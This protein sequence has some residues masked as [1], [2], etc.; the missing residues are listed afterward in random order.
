MNRPLSDSQHRLNHIQMP[1]C[2]LTWGCLVYRWLV[3]AI[4]TWAAPRKNCSAELSQGMM[5]KAVLTWEFGEFVMWQSE[6]ITLSGRDPVREWVAG[7]GTG[8][9]S[10]RSLCHCS[11]SRW[12]CGVRLD[13]K[14]Q[15]TTLSRHGS[16]DSYYMSLARSTPSWGLSASS[17]RARLHCCADV[18]LFMNL[19]L[20]LYKPRT[21]C[22]QKTERTGVLP[23]IFL[24]GQENI[25]RVEKKAQAQW[26][27]AR[28]GLLAACSPS[29][30]A[31]PLSKVRNET[32]VWLLC[33][34]LILLAHEALILHM[35]LILS[36]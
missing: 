25:F 27:E 2:T 36:D 24:R 13:L 5:E 28:P 35:L 6:S 20:L 26:S 31:L 32:H 15:E 19:G 16:G 9:F 22:T 4:M 33:Y 8:A 34:L 30:G 14:E 17:P 21:S 3:L 18:S 11:I 23:S 12:C 7:V 10:I 29:S 1:S